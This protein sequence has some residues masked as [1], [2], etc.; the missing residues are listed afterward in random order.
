MAKLEEQLQPNKDNNTSCASK[1]K[2]L[3]ITK[4]YM[5]LIQA[6]SSKTSKKAEENINNIPNIRN[7]FDCFSNIQPRSRPTNTV[8]AIKMKENLPSNFEQSCVRASFENTYRADLTTGR[9]SRTITRTVPPNRYK[10]VPIP[11]VKPFFYSWF[12]L[13]FIFYFVLFVFFQTICLFL[14][15]RAMFYWCEFII[16]NNIS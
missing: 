3:S 10:K 11:Q 12:I 1:K 16:A 14:S 6:P 7:S 2:G 9:V 8:R 13:F 4:G 5:Q 15:F